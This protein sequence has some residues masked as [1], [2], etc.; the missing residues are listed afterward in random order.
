MM[1]GGQSL[2]A[3]R[4]VQSLIAC[5][6][7]H[8]HPGETRIRVLHENLEP[9]HLYPPQLRFVS[10]QDQRQFFM[11]LLFSFSSSPLRPA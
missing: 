4:E 9:R 8:Q 1:R 3:F 7:Q 2:F 11:G 10:E 5:L 6:V